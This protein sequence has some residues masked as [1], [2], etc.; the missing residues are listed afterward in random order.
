MSQYHKD[1]YT[2]FVVEELQ[3]I[4]FSNFRIPVCSFIDKAISTLPLTMQTDLMRSK[5]WFYY[6]VEG[7]K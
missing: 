2:V 1:I 5:L 3:L 7:M 4:W 6:I